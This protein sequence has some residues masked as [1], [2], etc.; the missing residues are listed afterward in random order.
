[1][2]TSLLLLLRLG[3]YSLVTHQQAASSWQGRKHP[4]CSAPY[5]RGVSRLTGRRELEKT[6]FSSSPRPALL[7]SRLPSIRATRLD[8]T[9]QKGKKIEEKKWLDL[10]NSRRGIL[11]R[12]DLSFERR[13]LWNEAGR[14]RLLFSSLPAAAAARP[15]FRPAWRRRSFLQ[16]RRRRRRGSISRSSLSWAAATRSWPCPSCAC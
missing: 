1:M 14:A 3:W 10:G 2:A 6:E 11:R 16:A 15:M 12:K 5:F 8:G 13:Q 7:A 9:G 4:S